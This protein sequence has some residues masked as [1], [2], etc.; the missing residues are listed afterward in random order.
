MKHI[1]FLITIILSLTLFSCSTVKVTTDSEK[2]TNFSQYKTYSFL[3]WQ[4]NSDQVMSEFDRKHMRDAFKNEF[5]KRNLKF[6]KEGGDMSISLFIVVSKETST[7]A[8]TNYYGGYG[9]RYRRYGGGWGTG[10]A[11]TT[12]SENDYLKGTLVMDVFDEKSGDMVWQGVAIKTIPENSEK[13]K[14][15]ISKTVEALMNKFPVNQA[16]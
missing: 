7:T 3:G 16:E 10:Y 5:D 12:Y 15:S 8:Y 9:G 13:R 14:K 4:K 2:S 6:M 1:K 11:T